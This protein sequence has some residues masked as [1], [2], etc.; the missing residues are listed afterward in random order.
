MIGLG[1]LD[2]L[3]HQPPGLSPQNV[4]NRGPID[5]CGLLGGALRQKRLR[6]PLTWVKPHARKQVSCAMQNSSG[7]AVVPAIER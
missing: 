2:L 6:L 7:A 3:C 4:C 5:V 1:W